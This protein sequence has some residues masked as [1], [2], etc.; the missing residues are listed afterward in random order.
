MNNYMQEIF[1]D[2]LRAKALERAKKKCE[3]MGTTLSRVNHVPG[4]RSV[5]EELI[6]GCA[7]EIIAELFKSVEK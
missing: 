4:G 2:T 7:R 3:S 6:E 1:F 5:R